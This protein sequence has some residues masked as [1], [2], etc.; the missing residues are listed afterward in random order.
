MKQLDKKLA[1]L[2][3]SKFRNVANFGLPEPESELNTPVSELN[4][5]LQAQLLLKPYPDL[6]QRID[7]LITN[8]KTNNAI[9]N[10]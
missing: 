3:A 4:N 1:D 9:S 10:L 7:L 6:V 2:E 5:L 8:I